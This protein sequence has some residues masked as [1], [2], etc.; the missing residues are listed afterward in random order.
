M[1]K[2]N[3]ESCCSSS[4]NRKLTCSRISFWFENQVNTTNA[5]STS[6]KLTK[7][8]SSCLDLMKFW[9]WFNTFTMNPDCSGYVRPITLFCTICV[10]YFFS[11][12]SSSVPKSQINGNLKIRNRYIA[13]LKYYSCF[14][15]NYIGIL[16]SKYVH[17]R[18]WVFH[19]HDKPVF[20]VVYGQFG[21][22]YFQLWCDSQGQLFL[23]C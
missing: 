23:A 6:L 4:F 11:E 16:N 2:V 10:M 21:P 8:H 12:S 18:N 17:T 20:W 3:F 14:I 5:L 7:E 13:K 22:E 9:D 15:R 19:E 1:L